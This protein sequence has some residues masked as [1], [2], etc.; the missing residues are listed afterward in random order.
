MASGGGRQ[1]LNSSSRDHASLWS[2]PPP[3]CPEN[4]RVWRD[5]EKKKHHGVSCSGRTG[6]P[7]KMAV[8]SSDTFVGLH[9]RLALDLRF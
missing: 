2:C 9:R 7:A 6:T 8:F 4:S 5:G 1:A 3:P